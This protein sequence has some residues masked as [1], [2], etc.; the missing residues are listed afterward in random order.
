VRVCTVPH[1]TTTYEKG[2]VSSSSWFCLCVLRLLSC[3]CSGAQGAL[4]GI[5]WRSFAVA[6][7]ASL[8]VR[9][10]SA[11]PRASPITVRV[12]AGYEVINRA[13]ENVLR[14][15][16][17]EAL[18]TCISESWPTVQDLPLFAVPYAR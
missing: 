8:P 5:G 3:V 9:L 14:F 16:I 17:E 13:G 10:C 4:K 7:C 6:A 18:R 11:P 2:R 15:A 12:M 1:G